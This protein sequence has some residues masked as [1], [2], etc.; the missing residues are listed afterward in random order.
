MKTFKEI[1]VEEYATC[2][3]R[4]SA[5]ALVFTG[6]A[7]ERATRRAKEYLSMLEETRSLPDD[8]TPL[9]YGDFI[10]KKEDD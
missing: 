5:N 6:E 4:W 2:Y 7:Q 8:I 1:L 9:E 3:K 10:K